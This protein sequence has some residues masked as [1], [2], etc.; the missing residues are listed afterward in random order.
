[1]NHIN[2][3]TNLGKEMIE[4]LSSALK[5][6]FSIQNYMHHPIRSVE[7]SKSLIGLDLNKPNKKTN[8]L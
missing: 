1:M 5:Q 3:I 4:L 2:N 6:P 7:A 8:E